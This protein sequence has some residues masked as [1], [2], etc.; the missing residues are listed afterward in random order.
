[1][2]W[3][4]LVWPHVVPPFG[5]MTTCASTHNSQ[6]V[7]SLSRELQ[8][9]YVERVWRVRDSW[10]VEHEH[11]EEFSAALLW[12]EFFPHPP[13]LHIHQNHTHE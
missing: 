10:S 7:K 8:T 5:S 11:E 2:L 9:G 13:F 6:D 1:M 12:K 4:V 3:L